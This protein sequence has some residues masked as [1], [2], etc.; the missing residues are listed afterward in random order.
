MRHPRAT[1][2]GRL[3]A[4]L[5]ILALGVGPTACDA[6]DGLIGVIGGP[7]PAAR[8]TV[9]ID[10]DMTFDDALAILYLLEN[11]DVD[12]GAITVTGTGFASLGAGV[13]NALRLLALTGDSTVLVVAG[14]DESRSS[15]MTE[16]DIPPDLRTAANTLRGIALPGPVSMA[17][18]APVEVVLRDILDAAEGDVVVL[19]LGPL[20]NLANA[21]EID[22]NLADRVARLVSLG[23][24]FEVSGNVRPDGFMGIPVAE[25]NMYLDPV[26]AE[27]AFSAGIPTD[28]IPLDAVVRAPL[29]AAFA[30]RF[31][32][33]ASRPAARFVAD[34]LTVLTG[35]GS[36]RAGYAFLDA[37]AAIVATDPAVVGFQAVPVRVVTVGDSIGLTLVDV[38]GDSMRVARTVDAPGVEDRLIEVLTQ[39]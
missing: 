8:I 27:E 1:R 11:D 26:A 14:A 13:D 25:W 37:L 30:S 2:Q 10:T 34:G 33:G 39:D 20:T 3:A 16:D 31:Q 7:P 9:V 35:D 19:T 18:T 12:V 6:G 15:G 4:A 22:P 21:L 38:T 29:T 28:L 23:G 36:I 5:T 24:A 17:S 32:A